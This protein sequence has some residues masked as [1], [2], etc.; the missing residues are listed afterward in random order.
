MA[1]STQPQTAGPQRANEKHRKRPTRSAPRPA[2]TPEDFDDPRAHATRVPGHGEI[3]MRAFEI[4]LSRGE[5]PGNDL[6]DWL[7]AERQLRGY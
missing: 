5:W 4:Y 6:D 7:Q 2:T 1:R 3:A